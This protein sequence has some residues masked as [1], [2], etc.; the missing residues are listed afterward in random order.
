MKYISLILCLVFISCGKISEENTEDD[1]NKTGIRVGKEITSNSSRLS[2]HIVDIELC[3]VMSFTLPND[4][5]FYRE[6]IKFK[7][8]GYFNRFYLG[9]YRGLLKEKYIGKWGADEFSLRASNSQIDILYD[10]FVKDNIVTLKELKRTVYEDGNT[11]ELEVTNT[12]LDY[13]PC[14]NRPLNEIN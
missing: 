4:N 6:H 10:V 9:T 7:S 14:D 11:I 2:R 13:R 12:G 8:S 5:D 3:S 1:D